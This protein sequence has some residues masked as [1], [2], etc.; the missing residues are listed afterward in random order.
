MVAGNVP[1]LVHNCGGAH[2]A[3]DSKGVA[4]DLDANPLRGTR[5]TDRVNAQIESG[6]DHAFPALIDELPTWRDTTV[7]TGRDG[8]PYTHVRLPGTGMARR[9]CT[10]G[11]STKTE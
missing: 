1:V 4:T 6:D 7:E 5:H 8:N 9:A 11:S 10:I 2:F 3:V